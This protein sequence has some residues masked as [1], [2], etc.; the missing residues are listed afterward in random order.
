MG[1][2]QNLDISFGIPK[3]TDILGIDFLFIC[4]LDLDGIFPYIDIGKKIIIY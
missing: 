3:G 4:A 1:F 2:Y